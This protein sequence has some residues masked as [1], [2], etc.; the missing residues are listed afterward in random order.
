MYIIK[1]M[2]I[3][4]MMNVFNCLL[5]WLFQFIINLLQLRFLHNK[6]INQL[7]VQKKKS[8]NLKKQINLQQNLSNQVFKEMLIIFSLIYLSLMLC[9]N[10]K[11]KQR[12][13]S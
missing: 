1:M 6:E 3:I 5:K 9:F 4:K 13:N 10:W 11:E 7:F 12:N 2:H 8:Q